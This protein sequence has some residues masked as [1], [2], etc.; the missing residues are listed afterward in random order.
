[1]IREIMV[2]LLGIAVAGGT[3]AVTVFGIV[4]IFAH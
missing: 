2:R 1:M 4:F 3:V